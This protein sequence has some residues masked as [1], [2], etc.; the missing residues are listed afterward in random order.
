MGAAV[1]AAAGTKGISFPRR[2]ADSCR[3]LGMI[4]GVGAVGTFA[5]AAYED[6]LLQT[7]SCRWDQRSHG[8]SS[9]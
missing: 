2:L 9:S 5:V 1:A 8:V 7:C 6:D 4:V 3:E